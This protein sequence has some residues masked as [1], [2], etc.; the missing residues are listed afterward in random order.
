MSLGR[1]PRQYTNPTESP[2][3]L[4]S[5]EAIWHH[6]GCDIEFSSAAA[7][8]NCTVSVS[9]KEAAIYELTRSIFFNFYSVAGLAISAVGQDG[10]GGKFAS[11]TGS[12]ATF[13]SNSR[14]GG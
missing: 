2:Y 8:Q 9:V 6:S 13:G 10:G 4:P 5:R 14:N 1:A 12:E 3:D 7:R 11:L